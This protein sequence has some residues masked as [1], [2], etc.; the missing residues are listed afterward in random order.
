FSLIWRARRGVAVVAMTDPPVLS[1]ISAPICAL[2]GARSLNWLQDLFPEVA[3]RLGFGRGLLSRAG[4]LLLRWVRNLTLRHASL[5][6]VLGSE[7]AGTIG[8][9]GIPKAKICTIPNWAP[10]TRIRPV[11]PIVNPLRKAWMLEEAFVIGYSGNLGRA[12]DFET[13]LAAI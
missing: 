7:M 4:F 8:N 6:I 12:H 9:L 1:A 10:A 11:D 2:K 13:F 3:E 5:N